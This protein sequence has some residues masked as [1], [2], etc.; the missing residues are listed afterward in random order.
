[1]TANTGLN[2]SIISGILKYHVNQ[3]VYPVIEYCPYP[4][5]I[6]NGIILLVGMI[7]KYE[8]R[9][10]VKRTEHNQEIQF[11]CSKV[12]TIWRYARVMIHAQHV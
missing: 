11:H 3:A 7:G 10:Y 2:H 1:M 5:T 4:G 12:N 6:E 9:Y 8:Y